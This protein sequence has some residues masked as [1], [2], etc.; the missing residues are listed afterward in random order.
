MRKILFVVDENRIGGVSVVVRDILLNLDRKKYDVDLLVLHDQNEMLKDL[1]EHINVLYGTPFFD[2]I[3]YTLS[4]ILKT[5]SLKLILKKVRII[6]GLKTGWIKYFILNERKK[7]LKEIKYDVEVAA[8]DGFT[9]VFTAFGDSVKKVHWLHSEYKET[10]SNSNYLHLFRKVLSKFEQIVA[11]SEGVEKQF[12][13]IYHMEN[14]TMVIRNLIMVD[15]IKARGSDNPVYYEADKIN[16]VLV[17][18]C[19]PDKGYDRMLQVIRMMYDNNQLSKLQF[20]I[21]GDGPQR[22]ELESIVQTNNLQQH[23]K[24]YGMVDNPYRYMK[25]ADCVF[26]PSINESF[27]LV[28]VESQILGVPV[29]ATKNAATESIINNG[30]TGIVVENT[31]EGVKTGIEQMCN[32]QRFSQFKMNL[33]NYNYDNTESLIKLNEILE[34]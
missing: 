15:L 11:V 29:V 26:L 8:K 20:H 28:A 27:G 32:Q 31:D 10:N 23:V 18:R 7:I 22:I 33:M 1:P 30:K 17:G 3:D 5:K 16:V 6:I 21:V 24:F 9:A 13:A 19:H 25:N 4:Q 14:K 12:N 34:E 2:T